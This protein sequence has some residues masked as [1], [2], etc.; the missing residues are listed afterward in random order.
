[1]MT[2]EEQRMD[3]INKSNTLTAE[4]II[5]YVLT[6]IIL[7]GLSF[8][9]WHILSSTAEPHASAFIKEDVIGLKISNEKIPANEQLRLEWMKAQLQIVSKRYELASR[10]NV[11]YAYVKYISFVVGAV[12]CLLGTIVIFKGVR[13]SPIEA[14]MSTDQ[15]IRFKISTSS[16]GAFMTFLGTAI[17]ITSI[18]FRGEIVKTNDVGIFMSDQR[19]QP[20]VVSSTDISF[21]PK[22]LQQKLISLPK[23]DREELFKKS[24]PEIIEYLKNLK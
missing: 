20:M 17:I 19:T 7:V 4:E 3:Q 14:G 21:L 24:Q 11:T 9:F 22:D 13:P 12:L 1:M 5:L 23:K 10:L 16:P 6:L 2:P 15:Q 8:Y 18:T